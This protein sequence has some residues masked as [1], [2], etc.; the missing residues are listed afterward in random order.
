MKIDE[1]LNRRLLIIVSFIVFI[2]SLAFVA[3]HLTALN[4][5][6]PIKRLLWAVLLVSI[7]V[8][9]L[10][11][12]AKRQAGCE[13]E[14]SNV[15]PMSTPASSLQ[16]SGETTGLYSG[17]YGSLCLLP[18]VLLVVWLIIRTLFRAH[19]FVELEVLMSW[20][21]PLLL[22]IAGLM[23][24]SQN[25]RSWFARLIVIAGLMQAVILSAQYFGY[26]LF[27]SATTASFGRDAWK[28]VGTIGYQNQGVDFVA[29]CAAF[30]F[31]GVRSVTIRSGLFIAIAGVVWMAE[32]RGGIIALVAAVF[33][34]H[35][36]F[37]YWTVGRSRRQTQHDCLKCSPG[38]SPGNGTKDTGVDT[39][40]TF[41][42]IGVSACIIAILVLLS[43][44]FPSATTRFREVFQDYRNSTAVQSRL[45][46]G[47]VAINMFRE[48][49]LIGHGAGEYAFQYIDRLGVVYPSE[50]THAMLRATVFAREAHNDYLQ[51]ACE[52]GLIGMALLG[53][54]LF[55]V[56]RALWRMRLLHPEYM[57]A[58]FFVII[59]MAASSLVSFP[60]QT[61]MAGPLAGLMLGLL[62]GGL[63]QNNNG[64]PWT[65]RP[66][67][68]SENGRE[69]SL[70]EPLSYGKYQ[71]WP[72]GRCILIFASLLLF[73]FYAQDAYLNMAVPRAIEAG[74][75]KRAAQI[76]PSYAHRYQAVVGAAYVKHGDIAKADE[77]LT[78]AY[79]GYRELVLLN[80][81]GNVLSK[82]G[83][84]NEAQ[85]VYEK[86][87]G[88][89]IGASHATALSNLSIACE[90]NGKYSNAATALGYRLTL[91]P[92][93]QSEK[94]VIRL[95]YL[96]IK[97]VMYQKALDCLLAREDKCRAARMPAS[98]ELE[99]MI[100]VV[101]RLMG[102]LADAEDRFRFALKLNPGLESAIK[103]LDALILHR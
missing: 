69:R 99:N 1:L 82:Q 84:W 55:A 67:F 14:S 41:K 50:K 33:V 46:L 49:P 22:F 89:G 59:Y 60:W 95:S 88:A 100:G 39:G 19:P 98:A 36:M 83:K 31:I 7:A 26:D 43:I 42:I 15:V 10:R 85:S 80:N 57:I 61:S 102:K 2:I 45:V 91:W 76:I 23:V 40:A 86:W 13:G 73:A 17:N 25:G 54:L 12:R 28:M 71:G 62:V 51:F 29:I 81:L 70:A 64:S 93:Q 103:N 6:D 90:Q 56:M 66:T 16:S 11:G 48:K 101:Y 27:F 47:Q 3:P 38:V 9:G 92:D 78:K 37:V 35:L 21:L 72:V 30:L 96:W 58:G 24:R 4:Y 44:S 77:F 8:V 97:A 65:V 53:F 63:S 52:F 32:N 5:F 94:E 74:D 68:L 79:S 34:S 18:A 20:L 87:A 75:I